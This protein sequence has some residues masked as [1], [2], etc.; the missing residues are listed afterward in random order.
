MW[1]D[2]EFRMVEWR[3]TSNDCRVIKIYA[4]VDVKMQYM[5][6]VISSLL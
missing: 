2:A 6:F 4:L 5:F 3:D 1:R